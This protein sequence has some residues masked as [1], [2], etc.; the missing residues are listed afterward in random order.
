LYEYNQV[1]PI[2]LDEYI[3]PFNS[4]NLI[5]STL[6]PPASQQLL[7]QGLYDGFLESCNL[8][9]VETCFVPHCLHSFGVAITHKD[10]WKIAYSGDC[11][12]SVDLVEI[13]RDATVLI[14]EATLADSQPQEAL[15]K[16]H[17]TTSE[18]INIGKKMN[19]KYVLLTHFSQKWSKVPEFVLAWDEVVGQERIERDEKFANVGIAFDHMR[20]RVGDIWK[21]PLMYPCFQ[22]IYSDEK[23]RRSWIKRKGLMEQQIGGDQE[24]VS[25]TREAMEIESATG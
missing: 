10:G 4:S 5:P 12:P 20:V 9:S 18:A 13:G 2:E 19:A 25:E 7:N 16:K 15:D 21:L 22:E 23:E 14:H 17:S 6:L 1:D 3:I 8:A 11:R 24:T